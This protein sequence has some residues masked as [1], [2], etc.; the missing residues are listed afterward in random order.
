MEFN[1]ISRYELLKKVKEI[2]KMLDG[3]SKYW[4]LYDGDNFKQLS[5]LSKQIKEIILKEISV[6]KIILRGLHPAGTKKL[7]TS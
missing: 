3:Y 1:G 6:K 5:E 4:S 2:D 7:L